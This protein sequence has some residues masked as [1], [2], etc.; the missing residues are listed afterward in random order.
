MN[1]DLCGRPAT[2]STGRD[3]YPHRRDLWHKHFWTCHPCKA[4]VGCHDG[5]TT[6]L[7]GMATEEMRRW[8]SQAHQAFDPI[9]KKQ[10]VARSEAYA[11]LAEE[12]GL[13]QSETHIGMFDVDQCKATVRAVARRTHARL[14]R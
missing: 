4:R 9:W 7:G 12:L 13:P 5:T 14:D 10:G 1:C 8:R 3:V 2:L 6:A 11:W